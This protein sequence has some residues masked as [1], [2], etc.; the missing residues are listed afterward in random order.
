MEIYNQKAGEELA[1]HIV[2]EA[3]NDLDSLCCYAEQD[4]QK[5]IKCYKEDECFQEIVDNTIHFFYDEWGEMLFNYFNLFDIP[6]KIMKKADFLKEF[7][8][9]NLTKVN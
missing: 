3:I 7:K 1:L 8:E 4:P 2:L 5:I 6:K 9:K